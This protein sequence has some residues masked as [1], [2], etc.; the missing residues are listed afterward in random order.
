M[1]T[2]ILDAAFALTK[3]AEFGPYAEKLVAK[4]RRQFPEL[5]ERAA[6]E[7]RVKAAL[8]VSAACE[9]AEQFRGPTNDGTGVPSFRLADRC[10]GFSEAT[11]SDAEAWGLYLTK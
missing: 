11:Y 8:L 3:Q 7:A 5:D 10:S 9:W 2:E 4:I 1:T 6:E